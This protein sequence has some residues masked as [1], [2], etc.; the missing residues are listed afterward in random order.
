MMPLKPIG[1]RAKL[2]WPSARQ[3]RYA[4]HHGPPGCQEHLTYLY[5]SLD[6]DVMACNANIGSTRL[7]TCYPPAWLDKH[8]AKFAS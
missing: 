8:A 5:G 6:P 3:L 1:K 2:N 4:C 7:H